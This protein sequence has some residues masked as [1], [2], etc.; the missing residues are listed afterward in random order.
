MTAPAART[1][2][3]ALVCLLGACASR[4]PMDDRDGGAYA[5]V[6]EVQATGEPGNYLFSVAISSPDSGCAR[7]A[8]WW[9]VIGANGTLVYRRILAHSHVEEQPFTRS[10]GPVAIAADQEV[11]VRAHM[12]P[13]GYGGALMRGTVATGFVADTTTP[14]DWAAGLAEMQPLPD[15]CAF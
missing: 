11:I 3:L 6:I 10:G 9:E 13:N 2:A 14:A 8:D 15:G 1:G 7:Y 4:A 5:D 12:H